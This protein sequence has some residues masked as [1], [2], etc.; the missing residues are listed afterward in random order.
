M[1]AISQLPYNDL[2]IPPQDQEDQNPVWDYTVDL[3]DREFRIVLRYNSR[4]AA[5]YF[6]LYTAEDEPLIRGKRL[7]VQDWSQIWK[8]LTQ[9][10]RWTIQTLPDQGVEFE[11]SA[12]RRLLIL[13]DVDATEQEPEYEALG[14]SHLIWYATQADL[15]VHLVINEALQPG[16]DFDGIRVSSVEIVTP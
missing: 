4:M 10:P 12:G 13:M 8:P 11:D 16:F 3:G 6:D 5:W 14:R 1:V 9:D 2:I 15:L 7:V